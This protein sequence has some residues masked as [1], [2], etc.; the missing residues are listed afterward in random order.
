MTS[1]RIATAKWAT[2]KPK[3]LKADDVG[4]DVVKVEVIRS[5]RPLTLD[6]TLA[7]REEVLSR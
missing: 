2:P 7:D 3:P 5:G 4:A 6:I 1:A